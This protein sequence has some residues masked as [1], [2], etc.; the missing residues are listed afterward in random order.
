MPEIQHGQ[1]YRSCKPT[2]SMPGEHYIRIRIK[3]WAPYGAGHYGA[4]KAFVVTVCEDG[5]EMRPRSI[6]LDQLHGSPLTRD[7]QPRRTGYVLETPG[8]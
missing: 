1:I 6:S 8:A 2:P 7:G 4:G 3:N 5:M